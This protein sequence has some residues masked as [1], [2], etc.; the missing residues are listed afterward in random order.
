M[1]KVKK[2]YILIIGE[3]DDTTKKLSIEFIEIDEKEFIE[4]ELDISEIY[5]KEELIEKIN[6]IE[7]KENEYYKIIL[8]GN[9]NF[10]IN[11]FELLKYAESSNLIKIKDNTKISYDLEKIASENNLKGIFVKESLEKMKENPESE[12][13][14]LKAIE[15]GLE[16]M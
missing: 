12:E 11:R 4:F 8:V 14:I 5:S 16:A 2:S 3:I 7:I 10:E 15:I 6:S 1:G 9:R 13:E